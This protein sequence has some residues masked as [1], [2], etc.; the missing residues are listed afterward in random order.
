MILY[1]H[2]INTVL[3]YHMNLIFWIGKITSSQYMVY[4]QLNWQAKLASD[5]GLSSSKEIIY[6]SFLT[7]KRSFVN[8]KSWILK[9]KLSKVDNW[10]QCQRSQ[11]L[12][13]DF[14]VLRSW[15]LTLYGG[16]QQFIK[17]FPAILSSRMIFSAVSSS[18]NC[19]CHM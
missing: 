10:N 17:W 19:L 4:S 6:L 9:Q 2:K 18:L 16:N 7:A 14:L 1:H 8:H 13:H 15:L 3:R 5:I 12:V 11:L